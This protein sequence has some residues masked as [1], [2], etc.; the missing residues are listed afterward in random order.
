MLLL[1]DEQKEEP[2][3]PSNKQCS[4]GSGGPLDRKVLSFLVTA[5]KHSLL[6]VS[7]HPEGPATGQ[8]DQCFSWLSKVLEQMPSYKKICVVLHASHAHLPKINSKIFAKTQPCRGG[9]FCHYVIL[10][11][12]HL[13]QALN[14]FPVLHTPNGAV[15]IS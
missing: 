1:P 11:T 7:V 14:F 12:Q 6:E 15:P 8:L 3:E 2:W 5:D 10:Q 4:F 13:A 9:Q